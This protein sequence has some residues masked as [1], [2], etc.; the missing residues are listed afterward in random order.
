MTTVK[1]DYFI[2][3][4]IHPARTTYKSSNSWNWYCNPDQRSF[5]VQWQSTGMVEAIKNLLQT[6]EYTEANPLRIKQ[7]DMNFARIVCLMEWINCDRPHEMAGTSVLNL[8]QG[9]R[10]RSRTQD[11]GQTRILG[12]TYDLVLFGMEYG[13]CVNTCSESI[14]TVLITRCEQC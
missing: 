9:W 11:Y 14:C 7:P 2:E 4:Q 12:R 1:P 6:N 8:M 3:L 10:W 13:R 5:K